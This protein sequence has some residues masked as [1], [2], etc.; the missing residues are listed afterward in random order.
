MN[1]LIVN[2]RESFQKSRRQ[3]RQTY[4]LFDN[5]YLSVDIFIKDSFGTF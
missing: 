2:F 4:I 3:L 1:G 5:I